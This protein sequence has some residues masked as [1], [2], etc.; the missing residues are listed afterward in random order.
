LAVP[1]LWGAWDGKTGGVPSSIGAKPN[2]LTRTLYASI[3]PRFADDVVF[4]VWRSPMD[5][6]AL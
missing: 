3:V 2:D 5:K 4:A 1:A 6:L